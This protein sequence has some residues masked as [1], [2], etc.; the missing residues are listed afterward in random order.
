[1]VAIEEN[2]SSLW[3][4]PIG[5]TR[6]GTSRSPR[7]RLT[8]SAAFEKANEHLLRLLKAAVVAEVIGIAYV[9]A[10]AVTL[11]FQAK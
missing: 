1:M 3:T 9:A 2:H 6:S 5:M 8:A 7:S 11:L 4:K 10:L